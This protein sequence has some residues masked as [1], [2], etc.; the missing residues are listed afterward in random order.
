MKKMLN[1]MLAAIL[2]ISSASVVSSCSNED[3]PAW[4]GKNVC[5]N[6]TVEYNF[7]HPATNSKYFVTK[8]AVWSLDN[9]REPV[10]VY[11]QTVSGGHSQGKA[12]ITFP[13]KESFFVNAIVK[14]NPTFDADMVY[15][16]RGTYTITTFNARGEVLDKKSESFGIN[17]VVPASSLDIPNLELTAFGAY[18]EINCSIAEDGKITLE[19][20]S[21]PESSES[22]IKW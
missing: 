7:V 22:G 8:W 6:Y 4:D 14:E 19:V 21:S 5:T 9:K 10:P 3:T 1:W 12:D 13:A 11:S 17:S 18:I 15:D 2:T 20:V 16:N